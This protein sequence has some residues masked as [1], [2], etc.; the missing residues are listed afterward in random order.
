M[1]DRGDEGG[2]PWI[3]YRLAELDC[4]SGDW[5]RGYERA[6]AADRIA[7][8]TGQGALRP[9]TC[10]VVA[11]LAAHLGRVDEARAAAMEGIAAA[12]AARLPIGIGANVSAL[13]F[14]E[15]SLGHADQAHALLA[16]LIAALHAA[17][18]DE[19]TPLFWL[20]DEAEALVAIGEHEQADS[21]LAWLE[22]RAHALDH[23]EALA[24]AARGRALLDAARGDSVGALQGCEDALRHHERGYT[25]FQRGR[26]LLAKG[27]IAR[28]ARKWGLARSSLTD[29]LA[30]FEAL[31]AELWATRTR[32]ELAR[33]GGRPAA[34]LD[35]SDGERQVAE[36]VAAGRTNREVAEALFM[37]PRTVSAT[38]ARI[39]RKLGVG[40]RGELSA[41]LHGMSTPRPA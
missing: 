18:H 16:P 21:L 32:D 39:Y 27:Q 20:I 2:L 23:G 5:E 26:T 29:A 10:Y 6:T 7:I 36:L 28:R 15:L 41:R 11:L 35:L 17:G 14:L 13:G 30:V 33:I 9:P 4:W 1:L 40:S 19:T 38:L 37:S 3:W 34:K 8:Q 22:R 24:T 12:T 25:P 31:G